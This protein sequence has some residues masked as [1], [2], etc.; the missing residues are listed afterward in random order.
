MTREPLLFLA[1]RIPY[2]PDKGDKVRS[3]HFLRHLAERYRLFLG[4]FIDDAADLP[5]RARLEALCADSCFIRLRRGTLPVAAAR[6]LLR[7]APLTNF[8]YRS[9]TLRRW[10]EAT[11]R[12]E[13]IGKAFLFSSPMAQYL[14]AARHRGLHR[15]IDFVDVD[16]D[17]WRQYSERHRPPLRWLYQREQRTLLRFE[18]G[19]ARQFQASLFVSEHEATLFR[20]FAPESAERVLSVPNG[21][22]LDYFAPD[23]S[24]P[25]PYAP[26]EQVLVFTGA[27]DYWANIDAVGWFAQAIFP[28]LKARHPALRFYIVGS[29]P[30]PQVLALARTPDVVV[31]GRV[32]DVRPYLQHARLAVAPLRV[33]RGIQNKVLEAMAMGRP[34]V[35]SAAALEGITPQPWMQEIVAEGAE[36]MVERIDRLLTSERLDSLGALGRQTMLSHYSWQNS[37]HLLDSVI[38]NRAPRSLHGH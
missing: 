23:A 32:A 18:R 13:P 37:Y 6:G 2:P 4:T 31:T 10:V 24:L 9:A 1:H 29:N 28:R 12:R 8:H 30:A 38:E 25:S 33:A 36:A 35:V 26:Q 11:L 19:I 14:T 27:M 22:D 20:G 21:V 3:Y 7:G 34:I 15:V 17:K 5:H 16:S